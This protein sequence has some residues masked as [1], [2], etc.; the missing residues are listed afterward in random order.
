MLAK[1]SCSKTVSVVHNFAKL[2][3]F[4]VN[5]ACYTTSIRNFDI[6]GSTGYENAYRGENWKKK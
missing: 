5:C 2:S 3:T 1:A 6:K 4:G